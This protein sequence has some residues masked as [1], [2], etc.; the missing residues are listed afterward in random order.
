M[1]LI[2]KERELRH[3]ADDDREHGYVR[4]Q[5]AGREEVAPVAGP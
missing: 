3:H 4:H 2:L 5:V 1:L